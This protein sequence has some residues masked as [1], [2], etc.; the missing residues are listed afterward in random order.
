[1]RS[2]VRHVASGLLL[3]AAFTP[4]AAQDFSSRPIRM[5]VPFSA[6]GGTDISARLIGQKLSEALKTNVIVENKAGGNLIP[7]GKEVAGATPDGHTLYFISTS[8]L[9]T[10][11]LAPDYP[12]DLSKFAA[13][14]EVSVGPLI[15]AVRNDLGVKTS[16][17]W[18]ISPRKTPAS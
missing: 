17:T 6:G 11:S 16:A 4:A 7:A 1:M 3:A 5:I 2:F 8:A 9:I 13:V 18:S 10:Q 15:L 12:L 14:S